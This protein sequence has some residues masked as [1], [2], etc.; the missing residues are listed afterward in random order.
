MGTSHRL[1]HP[2]RES[3]FT[4]IELLVVIAIIAILAAL[5]LPALARAKEA[6]KRTQCMSNL[7]QWGQAMSLYV[8]D[9][10]QVF[11]RTK[12]PD[13]TPGAAPGYNEDNPTWTD[14]ADFYYTPPPQG[15]DAWFNALPP[16]IGSKPLYF[17]KAIENDNAGIANFNGRQNIFWCPSS[18]IDPLINDNIRV[19][20]NYGMNS[21]ALDD[22]PAEIVY[23]KSQMITHPSAF[24]MFSDGRTLIDE[25]PF[26]GAPAKESDIC[27]PQVYTSAFSSRH[28]QGGCI[29]FSDNHVAWFKYSYV[30][31]NTPAIAADPGHSDINW[32]ADGTVVPP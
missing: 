11:P 9:N 29:T 31:S 14:L 15:M 7:R 12:I 16:Y 30:C 27:K 32:A 1:S 19:A 21:K 5:L 23:L 10:N 2:K 22:A 4:L 8:D 6:A 3:G 20:L 26:Y 17:Y 25:A 18:I 24:V 13:G 28:V